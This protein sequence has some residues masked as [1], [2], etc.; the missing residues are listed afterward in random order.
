MISNR[1][2]KLRFIAEEMQLAFFLT[3]HLTDS[4][5]ARTLARHILIR[6]ENFIEHARG[7][8]RPLMNA[9]Y[10]TRDFHKTKEAYASAFEEYFKVSRHRLGAHVQDLDFGKRIELWNDIEIVKIS[11]LVDGA[12][13]I[14]RGLAPCNLPGY[15]P[16][17]DPPDLTDQAFLETLRQFQRAIE[18]RSWIE[19]G[20]DPLAMTRNN[21]A[22]V[23]NMTPVHARASQLALIRRWIA[24]Q[25]ILL[26]RLVAHP[27]IVRILKARIITDLVSFCDCLVTRQVSPGA[28][29]ATDG[30]DK[31]ITA[32]GQSSAP[33]DNF[34]AA[35]NFQAE[36][37]TARATRDT[38]GAHLE[39]DDTYTVASLLADLDAYDIG[40]GLRFYERV[41]AA[42]TKTCHSILFLRMYAADGQRLYGVSASHAPAVPYAANNSAG[43]PAPQE[44][45]P[46]KDEASYRKNLTRWLDGDDTQKGDARQFF[47]DAFAD[48]QAVETIEEVESFGTGQH[49]SRHEFRTAHKFLL[50]ALS[51][52]LS[53]FDFRGILELMLS[54]RSGSPY[55]LAEILVRHGRSASVFKRW[56]ICY[57]L[58]EIGS[59]PHASARRFLEACA[60]SQS[61]PIRLQAALARFKTFVKAEGIFRINHSGQMRTDYDAFAGSLIKPMSEPE[62]MVCLLSF[63]SILSGPC[64]GSFSQPFQSNYAALQTQIEKLCVPLLKDDDNRLKATT[65]KQLI[66]THDYVGVCVMVALELD[67]RDQHPLHAALMDNCCNGS[68]VTA[69]HDQASRHLAMCFLLKKEHRMAFEVAEALASRNPDWVDIQILVAQILGDTPGA[70]DEATQKIANLRRAYAL[71]AN[72]ELR[73]AAVETEIANRKASW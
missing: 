61:W 39:I 22:A 41:G 35:S 60:H 45:P 72:F 21:T 19:M 28:P 10:D 40:H 7:L 18:N 68:I 50:A 54:C 42:F 12:Q 31:L 71:N 34:V 38:V 59:A 62:R 32:N 57:A 14:Y 51:D 47:W 29:Q 3:M 4:F 23:L 30:L 67:G 49:M 43:S 37:Q 8:R 46:I 17:A 65:L 44:L 25:G 73:L 48:S 6:A 56:L 52:G 13:Q 66:Q 11:F 26:D 1:V 33:I 5:V 70:E 2:E 9:G 16:Y 36:L 69:G 20:T 64:V 15:V 24:I 27:P 55:P 58:G 63:A 53:D